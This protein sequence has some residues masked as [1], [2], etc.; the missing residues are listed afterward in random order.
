MCLLGLTNC[1]HVS[2]GEMK[3][4]HLSEADINTLLWLPSSADRLRCYMQDLI[5]ESQQMT[6]RTS[7]IL[8]K[9]ACLSDVLVFTDMSGG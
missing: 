8:L 6:A 7:V 2:Q 1:L 5:G 3:A 9:I 4:F